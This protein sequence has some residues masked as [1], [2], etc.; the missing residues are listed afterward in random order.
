MPGLPCR[1]RGFQQIYLVSVAS[2]TVE[3]SCGEQERVGGCTRLCGSKEIILL[4]QDYFLRECVHNS[5]TA[6]LK[7]RNHA[8]VSEGLT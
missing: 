1:G 3:A 2:V 5:W 7:N 8:G 6:Q 4:V